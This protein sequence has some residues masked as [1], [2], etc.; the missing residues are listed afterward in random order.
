MP[1]VDDLLARLPEDQRSLFA[2]HLA[3]FPILSDEE[4]D[5]DDFTL[6]R[7]RFAEP[8]LLQVRVDV[9]R[10]APAVWRR[11][12]LRSDLD[13]ETVHDALVATFSWDDD[14]LHMF[15]LGM[16]GWGN[17]CEYYYSSRMDGFEWDGAP[18]DTVF[19]DEVLQ[20]A[21]DK[22]FYEYDFG[23]SWELVLKL[24]KLLPWDDDAPAVVCT[25]GRQDFWEEYPDEEGEHATIPFD[26]SALNARLARIPVPVPLTML[27]TNI[28]SILA[29]PDDTPS[30]VVLVPLDTNQRDRLIACH[31]AVD[32]AVNDPASDPGA[33]VDALLS[34]DYGVMIL[35]ASHVAL[36]GDVAAGSIAVIEET[37]WDDAPDCPFVASI[38]LHPE[39]GTV[40][41]EHALLSAAATGL[42]PTDA[43]RLAMLVA[44]DV[45]AGR[46]S[47]YEKLGFAPVTG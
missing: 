5:V 45:P 31:R 35:G 2:E 9:K 3:E 26:Q 21:G 13:L 16:R 38:V 24:E 19:I 11:L 42:R 14:H 37:G 18:D 4:E 43:T 46:L 10:A 23:A 7:P 30:D 41:V 36:V 17:D 1:D 40:A 34:G 33:E 8:A 32:I 22:L 6:R 39:L 25:G 27:V 47:L 20:N 28:A 44:A 15:W 29:D 12:V